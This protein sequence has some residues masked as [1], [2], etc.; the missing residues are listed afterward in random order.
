MSIEEAKEY[1]QK[2]DV[3]SPGGFL[4]AI[5]WFFRLKDNKQSA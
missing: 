3:L 1:V 2:E 5:T 4:F